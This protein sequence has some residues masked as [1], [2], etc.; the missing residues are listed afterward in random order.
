MKTSNKLVVQNAD[1][2]LFLGYSAYQP[3]LINFQKEN[4]INLYVEPIING[5]DNAADFGKWSEKD[6]KK[7]QSGYDLDNVESTVY[8]NQEEFESDDDVIY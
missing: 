7:D 5:T 6:F 4:V 2:K 3:N 8:S 1:S